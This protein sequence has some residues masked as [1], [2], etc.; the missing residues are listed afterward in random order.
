MTSVVLELDLAAR[1][2]DT[3]EIG[4]RI[5]N[6]PWIDRNA[7]SADARPRPQYVHPRMTIRKVNDFPDIDIKSVADKREL[8]GKRNVCVA[9]GIFGQLYQFRGPRCCGHTCAPDEHLVKA[10]RPSGAPGSYAP[11]AAV[12]VDELCRIRPGRTRSGQ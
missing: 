4:R 3:S 5:D 10:L 6:K 7:V 8:V 9:K 12:V 1:P 11:D 2:R